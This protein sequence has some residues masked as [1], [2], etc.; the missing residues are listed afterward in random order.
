LSKDRLSS[1]PDRLHCLCGPN[2]Q[3]L[4]SLYDPNEWFYQVARPDGTRPSVLSRS[5]LLQ[6]SL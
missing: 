1:K 5:K 6:D 2:E 3:F 4:D